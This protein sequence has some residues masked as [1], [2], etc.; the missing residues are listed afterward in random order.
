MPSAPAPGVPVSPVMAPGPKDVVT[1]GLGAGRVWATVGQGIL[2]EV[3]WPS[4]GEPQI[5]DM[6]FI[7]AGDGWWYEVKAV[8]TYQVQTADPAVPLAAVVHT[9]PAEHPY[10]LTLQ[11][12]PDP[13][14]DVVLVSYT[15]DGVPDAQ[16]YVFLASHLQQHPLAN[17]DQDYSG[18]SGNTAWTDSGGSL[19]AQGAGR[20]L[21]LSGAPGFGQVSVGYFGSSDLWQDFSRNGSMTW[22][23]TDAGPG[24]VVLSGALSASSGAIA[25][26][27]AEDAGTAGSLAAASLAA[28]SAAAQAQLISNW[29]GWSGTCTFPPP[30]GTDPAD[31]ADAL[32]QSAAVLRVHQD[33]ASYPGAIVAGLCTPWG[34][35]TNNAGGY[36]LV[37][38]RD[39]IE[40][41]FAFTLLGQ[42]DDA[43]QL[44]GYLATRQ[45]PD[46]HWG[47]NFFPD[48]TPY[49]SGVQLDET[50]LPVML[51][52]KLDEL[53][54]PPSETII[55]MIN[56]A[57]GY[58]VQN[59]PLSPMD[60][61]E[62]DAGGSPFTLG[63]IV[64]AMVAG[65][66]YLDAAS[67]QYVLALADDWNERIEEWCYV[68]G[69]PLDLLFGLDGHYVR[70]GPDPQYGLARIANQ[71]YPNYEI[72][73]SSVLGLEFAYLAR[74]GL[75]SASDKRISDTAS[76]VDV[77]LARNVGTG[78]GYYRYD[79]DG[80]GEQVN[81]ANFSGVGVGRVWPLLTGER[82]HLAVLA[83]DD[84]LAQLNA[85][86]K[87]RTPSGLLPE[88]V[89]DQ[90]PLYPQNGVPTLPLTTG[91]RTLSAT[92]LVWAHS[93]LIKLAWTRASRTPAEQLTAV[94][95]RY[96]GQRP[97]PSTS[98]WRLSVQLT[99]LAAG[100]NLVVED[101][102]PFT[103]HYG[104]GDPANWTDVTETDSVPLPF[105]MN[106]VTL[107]AEQ[108]NGQTGLNFIRR[109]GN[110]TWDP[111]GNHT[112]PI[113]ATATSFLQH[114]SGH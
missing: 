8:A 42:L 63:V 88:Q 104:F 95:A 112:I 27:F 114:Q 12:I 90:S 35:T 47:Q 77:M 59:G 38:P 93:E 103:L 100:R 56:A 92:P 21:C 89:W 23:F 11:V 39:A 50:A 84:G 6:G 33:C 75:R 67:S 46:G 91:Q 86:L 20:F 68:A 5:R 110:G 54:Q 65:A 80:Y 2:H 111:S 28:G 55:A 51:A 24:F 43:A 97:T 98:H 99:G 31:L 113:T 17:A 57:I 60:R 62:E 49:W 87:M 19:F 79:Y 10:Q 3:Y 72:A 82:G 71:S 96:G 74:L 78:I 45:S 30:S 25:L 105:G 14:R 9:G 22:N 1:T 18:G 81:G 108:L 32:R 34:D 4:A 85:M 109:Y 66:K 58:L 41:G 7:V 61:W 73:A 15:L 102:Q 83:G 107:T 36:H 76:L 64:A 29:Q 70:I 52:A 101:T 94:T 37:W 44:L 40:T 106:G 16:L 26:A 13:G 53:G 69:S 48:G